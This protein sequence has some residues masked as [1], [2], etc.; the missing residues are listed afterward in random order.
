MAGIIRV[1]GGWV[2]GWGRGTAAP[3]ALRELA[4]LAA[5]K[6]AP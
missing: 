5:D 2:G 3:G 6:L 4:T 1:V